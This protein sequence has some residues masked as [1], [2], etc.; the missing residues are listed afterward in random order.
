MTTTLIA[1]F[2]LVTPAFVGDALGPA[3]L[4]PPP[5]IKGVLR[6]WWRAT[7]WSN[8]RAR[9]GATDASALHDLHQRE[10][11]LFGSAAGDSGGG[12]GVFLFDVIESNLEPLNFYKRNWLATDNPY[13]PYLLGQG[14]WEGGKRAYGGQAARRARLTRDPLGEGSFAL[15]LRF[16]RNV[17]TEDIVE[18]ARALWIFGHFGGI[19][20]RTRRG[21]GSVSLSQPIRAIGP[22]RLPTEF[23][24]ATSVSNLAEQLHA[25][26]PLLA[27]V[28]QP[29]FSAF[30]GL[31]RCDASISGP[32]AMEA[33]TQVGELFMCYR[34]FR[35]NP[36]PNFRPDH[37]W[38]YAVLAGY[39]PTDM[40]KRSI[41]GLPHNGFLTNRNATEPLLKNRTINVGAVVVGAENVELRRASPLLI[42]LQK[43]AGSEQFMVLQTM[44]TADYLPDGAM[45]QVQLMPSKFAPGGPKRE[46]APTEN[47][48]D[49]ERYL[50]QFS[51]RQTVMARLL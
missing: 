10:A 22:N 50:D 16:K 13:L 45:V 37:D 21:W 26:L 30:S 42:H 20:S 9:E 14:L 31:T 33:L 7:A 29:P 41:F 51:G 23:A 32:K 28:E 48:S 17:K 47:W 6:F 8:F 15:R 36:T 43:L 19:G 18:L 12:Q 44:L 5:S 49:I 4:L 38:L 11:Y 34:S 1:P 40:Q 24:P 3:Q 39:S 2:D 25:H 35:M 46:V 27:K